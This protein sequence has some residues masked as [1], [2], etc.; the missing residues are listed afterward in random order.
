MKKKIG[1]TMAIA[2]TALAAL[3]AVPH[4]SGFASTQNPE[5]N[6]KEEPTPSAADDP[7]DRP[8]IIYELGDERVPTMDPNAV[9]HVLEEQPGDEYSPVHFVDLG[10]LEVRGRSVAAL[11]EYDRIYT[12]NE[13]YGVN[14]DGHIFLSFS[15]LSAPISVS[16]IEC[17]SGEVVQNWMCDSETETEKDFVG[18]PAKYYYFMFQSDD[19]TITGYYDISWSR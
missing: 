6:G 1:F 12:H 9:V 5:E 3:T 16:M 15:E 7:Y 18:N 14:S 13:Y 19:K 4:L 10:R 2:I 11:S 17:E 8:L